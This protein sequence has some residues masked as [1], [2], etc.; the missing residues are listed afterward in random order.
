MRLI[1]K[2]HYLESEIW[3]IVESILEIENLLFENF[4]DYHGDIKTDSIFVNEEGIIKI[5]DNYLIDNNHSP[6]SKM[7]LGLTKIPL[8]PERMEKFRSINSNPMYD[9]EKAEVWLI[10]M[11]ILNCMS[12]THYNKFYNWEQKTI[13]T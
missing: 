3:Y 13:N 4:K 11:L 2:N 8:A 10:G 12:L 1:S 5:L 6:Y 7:L 9:K